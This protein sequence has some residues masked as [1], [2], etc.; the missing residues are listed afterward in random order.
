M[1]WTERRRAVTRIGVELRQR[2]WDIHG[3]KEDRSDA[4]TDYFDPASWDGIATHPDH[5]NVVVCVDVSNA[6]KSGKQEIET[7]SVPDQVCPRCNGDK[8][9][10]LGW[11]LD[12][13]RAEPE[14]YHQE[15]IKAKYGPNSNLVPIMSRVVSPI[16]FDGN[17]LK[18]LKCHGE[19]HTFKTEEVRRWTWPEFHATPK[20]KTWHVERDGKIVKTGV[21]L[22]KCADWDR[23]RAQSAVQHLVDKIEA[24]VTGNTQHAARNTSQVAA[25]GE[26]YT[27]EHDRSWTWIR[28]ADKPSE[29]VRQALKQQLGARWGRRRKAWYIKAHV[30]AETI[31]AVI[32]A[33][34]D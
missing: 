7:K 4:M 1:H 25:T 11:T 5:P 22:R 15:T 32:S 27:I 6:S 30:E 23:E 9:D 21:G 17:R 20:G 28:F 31:I 14:R 26:G 34:T 33:A 8:L 10:P 13:A 29:A 2:G 24:V 18:C 12:A 16:P 3:Y 19:G